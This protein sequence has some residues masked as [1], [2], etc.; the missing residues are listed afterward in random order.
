M[1]FCRLSRENPVD[2]SFHKTKVHT[3]N[4]FIHT[5]MQRAQAMVYQH[6][7][8]K[9]LARKRKQWCQGIT[10]APQPGFAHDLS[11]GTICESIFWWICTAG[12]P[13]LEGLTPTAMLKQNKGASLPRWASGR[14]AVYLWEAISNKTIW[15]KNALG[16]VGRP[17]RADIYTSLLVCNDLPV[18]L[19]EQ[20]RHVCLQLGV[21]LKFMLE[22]NCANSA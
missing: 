22:S 17:H 14:Q 16:A 21:I 6:E 15:N 4:C 12:S 11:S 5:Q 1:T 7:D 20:H 13:H 3:T 18:A 19:P 2:K 8:W 10:A 9:M